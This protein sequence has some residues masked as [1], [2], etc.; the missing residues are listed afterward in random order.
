MK[1]AREEA[2]E[3]AAEAGRK[4][5]PR[6]T[7]AAEAGAADSP[8]AGGGVGGEVDTRAKCLLLLGEALRD[9]T[10]LFDT[11]TA[12]EV[13]KIFLSPPRSYDKRGALCGPPH[14]RSRV[15]QCL[16]DA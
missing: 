4:K 3:E 9:P 5:K 8:P 11:A 12:V 10:P 16:P 2:A 15:V 7:A 14:R 13:R 6:C 1:K